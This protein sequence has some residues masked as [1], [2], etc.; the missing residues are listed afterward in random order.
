[1]YSA[2]WLN[3]LMFIHFLYLTF[4]CIHRQQALPHKNIE[5]ANHK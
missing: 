1:M 4:Q 2:L 3:G 5:A